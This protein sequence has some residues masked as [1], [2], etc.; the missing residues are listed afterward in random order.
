MKPKRQRIA[1][2][3]AGEAAANWRETWKQVIEAA[4]GNYESD[5]R[6][7]LALPENEA[8]QALQ[9]IVE[10]QMFSA[11][12]VITVRQAVPY[13]IDEVRKA[14]RGVKPI[15]VYFLYLIILELHH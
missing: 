1:N 10:T 9:E 15:N 11:T 7:L 3:K 13:L 4:K 6:R 8:W 14:F 2:R 5:I 12:S